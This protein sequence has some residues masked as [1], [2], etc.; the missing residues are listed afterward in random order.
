MSPHQY[1]H[2]ALAM[3]D[4]PTLDDS[5]AESLISTI[6]DHDPHVTKD[7]CVA[8]LLRI[9]AVDSDLIYNSPNRM[10]ALNLV[11][12]RIEV[13]G[14]RILTK[15]K[16]DGRIQADE[17]CRKIADIFSDALRDLE[18]TCKLYIDIPTLPNFRNRLLRTLNTDHV[19][20]SIVPFLRFANDP[21]NALNQC[22]RA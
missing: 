19:K 20:V 15:Y 7:Y 13:T 17:E 16:L 5:H 12:E 2:H 10:A 6:C 9:A 4:D 11:R 21:F 22:L 3:L 8:A 18:S 1:I 14:R